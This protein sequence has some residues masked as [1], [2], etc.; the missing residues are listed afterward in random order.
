[1]ARE[2]LK[3]LIAPPTFFSIPLKKIE[4]ESSPVT[5]RTYFIYRGRIVAVASYGDAP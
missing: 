3:L 1:M 2:G 4:V 5:N